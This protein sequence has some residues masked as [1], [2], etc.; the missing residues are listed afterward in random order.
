MKSVAF[1]TLGCKVNQTET[2]ALKNLFEGAGYVTVPFSGLADVYIINTCTVTHL[3]DRKSRQLIRR[4]RR[5]NPEAVVVVTGCYAQVSPDDVLAIPGVDLVIGTHSREKLPQLVLEAK[6][7]R[8][9]CVLPLDKKNCFEPLPSAQ[10]GKR[11]RAFLKV[12]EGCRQFCSY[13]I[14]P[15]ARGALYSRSMDAVEEEIRRLAGAGFREVVLTGVHLGSYGTDLPQKP[16]L[17]DLIARAAAVDGIERVRISSVEPTEVTHDLVDVMLANPKICRHL[18][19][20]MQS[21][22]DE[23]LHRMNR[24]YSSSEYYYLVR[25]LQTEVNGI[26]LTTDIM[27]GFPGETEEHFLQ[28]LKLVERCNFSRLHVFKYSMR[29]GTPAADFPDQVSAPVKDERSQRLIQLGKELSARYRL[30]FIGKTAGVLFE[31][32][33]GSG[34]LA[35]LTEHYVLVEAKA[36]TA[37]LGKIVQVSIVGERDGSLYGEVTDTV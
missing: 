37:H 21:G 1:Q 34:T 6:R 3:S 28:T 8:L 9:N 23:I 13:C 4:A 11:T 22:H 7:R 15:Y 24:K 32:R 5:I 29:H 18:H 16:A 17:S 20:P 33:A 27:V 31:K 26:A 10:T 36:P 14:V 12:Q 25:W 2:A 19:I 30:Q 35:G